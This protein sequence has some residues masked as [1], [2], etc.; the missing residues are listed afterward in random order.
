MSC[1]T[2]ARIRLP[3]A[4]ALGRFSAW[5]GLPPLG[6]PTEVKW[7]EVVDAACKDGEWCSVVAV[8]IYECEAWTVFDDQTGH[9][10]TLSADQWR[11]FAGQDELV[12]AGYDD[13]VPY[14]QLIVVRGGRVV[15]EFLD[16]EQDPRQ[17]VNQ[18]K[19]DFEQQSPIKD[20]ISAASLVDGD[21]IVSL[22]DTGLLWMFGEPA[23]SD[24]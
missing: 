2:Y 18:G 16:D 8:F 6:P 14:G 23:K 19:L 9:F 13:T 4:E 21:E 7:N 15:R 24:Q 12:V 1:A 10:A 5:I 3:M 17:N 20:W 22:P 11:T